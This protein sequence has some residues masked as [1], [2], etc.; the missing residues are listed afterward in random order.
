MFMAAYRR[1]E[2]S[3]RPDLDRDDGWVTKS[4]FQIR[5]EKAE[6]RAREE[7]RALEAKLEEQMAEA[8]RQHLA[9]MQEIA[10]VMISDARQYRPSYHEIER[11]AC[12]IFRVTRNMIRSKRRTREFIIPRH[13]IMYW[14]VR[15]TPLSYPQIGRLMGGRDHTTVLHGARSYREKRKHF[16]GRHLREAR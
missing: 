8:H 4:I 16:T 3:A 14:A 1:T 13:F 15:L 12:R 7:R 9:R 6:A 11:R 5:A 2:A 10:D